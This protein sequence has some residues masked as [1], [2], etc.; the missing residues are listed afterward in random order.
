MAADLLPDDLLADVLARLAPRWL[1]TSRCVCRSWRAAIDGRRL[2]RAD[3]L[4]LSLGGIFLGASDLWFPPFFSRPSS[5][6]TAACG[7]VRSGNLTGGGFD[8]FFDAVD[9]A[10][11]ALCDHCNG[12]LLLYDAVVNPDTARWARLPRPLP[13]LYYRD[14][15]LA[16]DPAVS[17]H[18]EVR[19]SGRRGRNEILCRTFEWDEARH[20]TVADIQQSQH[21]S[22]EH[23][24]FNYS[25]FWR[26]RLYVQ[27][28]NGFVMRINTCSGTCHLVKP[29]L[30]GAGTSK[31]RLYHRSE[32]HHRLYLGK[33][34]DGVYYA[35]V[36]PYK[37]R[38]HVW[39]LDESSY[40]QPEWVLRCE[41]NLK[42]LLP[43]SRSHRHRGDGPWLLRYLDEED[44]ADC[45]DEDQGQL[46]DWSSDMEDVPDG[47]GGCSGDDDDT[48]FYY[49][50]SQ[51][52]YIHFLGFHPFKEVVFLHQ[53]FAR[54][55]RGIAYHL[56]CSKI[57]DMGTLDLHCSTE[58]IDMS[59][60][61]T[62]CLMGVFPENN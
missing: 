12:L 57:Q 60:P 30:M 25:A 34:K 20:P 54:G 10:G 41:E 21:P 47:A 38:L 61:Y 26:G 18:Y 32:Y 33:S 4:P 42:P 59:F 43:P 28:R 51:T 5:T 45:D 53:S 22:N 29:P 27:F 55:E 7:G 35:S 48:E 62:P 14:T 36:D 37:C 50:E 24:Y 17:P 40:G 39:R 1:A 11:A 16:F 52:L 46:A 3:L 56:G 15:F 31:Y 13:E 9:A 58:H 2:L 44:A 8:C 19:D 23:D 6:G 49:S